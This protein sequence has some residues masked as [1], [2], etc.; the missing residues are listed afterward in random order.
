MLTNFTNGI[1]RR[2]GHVMFI[3]VPLGVIL[4][5]SWGIVPWATDILH[6]DYFWRCGGVFTG[7]D[8][9][10]CDWIYIRS[11]PYSQVAGPRV[12][13]KDLRTSSGHDQN[14][15]ILRKIKPT[16]GPGFLL[17]PQH[18]CSY[19]MRSSPKESE[20]LISGRWN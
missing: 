10:Y 20:I 2:R 13:Y 3:T 6:S 5:R 18:Y 15:A 1:I 7:H 11:F 8:S 16:V 12:D 9:W 14:V 17:R 19:A 4:L